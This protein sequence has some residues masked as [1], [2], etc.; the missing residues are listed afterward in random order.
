MPK[1]KKRVINIGC[2][3]TLYEGEFKHAVSYLK[4]KKIISKFVNFRLLIRGHPGLT[5]P[6]IRSEKGGLK[7]F[8][9]NCDLIISEE[10]SAGL[11]AMIY[12][13]PV[14]YF[15]PLY[16]KC[17]LPFLE[18]K[19]VL[20]AE[21]IYQVPKIIKKINSPGLRKKMLKNQKN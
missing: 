21:N 2:L 6:G 15:N 3:L 19:A 12:Q 11:E 4:L 18:Y 17:R 1:T 10:S 16:N 5:P 8:I 7:E 9:K 14:V 20:E 13:K